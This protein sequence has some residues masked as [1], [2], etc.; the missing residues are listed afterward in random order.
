[1]SERIEEPVPKLPRGRGLKFSGPEMFRILLTLVTLIGVLVLARPCATAVSGF[2]TS[3]DGSDTEKQMP[4][5][6]NVDVP[7]PQQEMELL[8]PDMTEA[9]MKAAIERSKARAAAERGSATSSSGNAASGS[10]ANG[11]A[12][13]GSGATGSAT[14]GAGPAPSGSAASGTTPKL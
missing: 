6:G 2:V 14:K 4:K 3:F 7:A 12:A 13:T 10:A 1:V 9:E 11:D 5:P 8:R